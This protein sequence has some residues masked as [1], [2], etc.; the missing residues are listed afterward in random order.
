MIVEFNYKS[1]LWLIIY[2]R[3]EHLEL[4]IV[5]KLEETIFGFIE[6]EVAIFT[7][8]NS[9]FNVLLEGLEGKFRHWDHR[10]EWT[11]REFQD[12]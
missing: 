8:P 9:D 5:E 7:T 11:R 12:W 10:F 6:P 3:I 4:D 1:N 2:F